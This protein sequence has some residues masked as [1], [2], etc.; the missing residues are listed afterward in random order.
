MDRWFRVAGS[1]GAVTLL[2]ACL[3]VALPTA[4]QAGMARNCTPG[5]GLDLAGCDYSGVD[6]VGADF[7]GAN[8]RWANF[9]NANLN[10]TNFSNADLR[11]ANLSGAGM[12]FDCGQVPCQTSDLIGDNLTFEVNPNFTDADLHGANMT[13]AALKGTQEV[14]NVCFGL[15]L[16]CILVNVIYPDTIFTG[17]RSGGIIGSPSSLPSGWELIDGYLTV[18]P[19]P[20]LMTTASNLP[21]ATQGVPYSTVLTAT[22]GVQPY[23]WRIASGMFPKGL[24]LQPVSGVISGT[25]RSAGL[26]IF[27]IQ[28][29][30]SKTHQPTTQR[31]QTRLVALQVT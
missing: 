11:H 8:L 16:H 31:T 19:P 22:G 7:S 30:D 25:P 13:G 4:A 14:T 5:P 28:V 12:V 9:S 23:K 1:F 2:S 27:T 6:V 10:E 20:L 15:P 26:S 24:H 21:T 29:T 18:P 17:V 3:F